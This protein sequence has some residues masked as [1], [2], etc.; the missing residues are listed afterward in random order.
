MRKSEI[1]IHRDRGERERERG[2]EPH[3]LFNPPSDPPSCSHRPLMLTTHCTPIS[4]APH[5]PIISTSRLFGDA[6]QIISNTA[7]ILT[8]HGAVIITSRSKA[9]YLAPLKDE[10]DHLQQRAT[11]KA[12]AADAAFSFR[13]HFEKVRRSRTGFAWPRLPRSYSLRPAFLLHL[14]PAQ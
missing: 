10:V 8:P 2:N 5:H 1:E 12:A 3:T 14:S 13:L 7:V 4:S 9:A 11:Q 6:P